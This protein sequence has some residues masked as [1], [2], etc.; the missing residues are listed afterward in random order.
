MVPMGGLTGLAIKPPLRKTSFS[1]NSNIIKAL[2]LP[3]RF[4]ALKRR[5]AALISDLSE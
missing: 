1:S 3:L 4:K 2:R 5:K